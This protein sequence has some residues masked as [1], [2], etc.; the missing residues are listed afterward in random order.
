MTRIWRGVAA[1][2]AAGLLTSACTEDSE[3]PPTTGPT[4]RSSTQEA[5]TLLRLADGQ[6]NEMFGGI[7]GTLEVNENGCFSVRGRPLVT[8]SSATVIE[9]G[10]WAIEF[11]DGSTAHVGEQLEGMGGAVDV[12]FLKIPTAG[13]CVVRSQTRAEVIVY[14]PS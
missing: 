14:T 5:P 10:E 1:A 13:D 7:V 11:A 2:L 3:G 8:E 4:S 6:V 12:D 9:D